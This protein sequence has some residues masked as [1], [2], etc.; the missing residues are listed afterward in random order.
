M[1]MSSFAYFTIVSEKKKPE[2]CGRIP[3]FSARLFKKKILVIRQCMIQGIAG[4][5]DAEVA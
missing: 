5:K 3:V 1:Y 4:E 2:N